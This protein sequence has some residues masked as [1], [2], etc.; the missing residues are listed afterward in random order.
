MA[1][2][3]STKGGKRPE[4]HI[5]A[6]KTSLTADSTEAEQRTQDAVHLT[7]RLVGDSL[8]VGAVSPG[9]G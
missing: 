8:E 4:V 5:R 6:G 3:V 2:P 9:Q 1:R 7:W